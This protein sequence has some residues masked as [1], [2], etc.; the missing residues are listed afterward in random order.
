RSTSWDTAFAMQALL[1][2]PAAET[3]RPLLRRACGF[4]DRA[5]EMGELADGQAQARD[6]IRGGWCFSEGRH[7]RPGRDRTRA[8]RGALLGADA[9]GI[10][11]EAER[12]APERLEAAAGFVIDR[13]NDDGGFG[14]YERRRGRRFLEKLNPSEMFGDCMTE[15]SYIECTASAVIALCRFRD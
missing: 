2:G 3:C 15:L 1:A 11:A 4:L 9:A 10:M 6:S 13:Q 12:L 7:R 5:Q 14:T 8:A